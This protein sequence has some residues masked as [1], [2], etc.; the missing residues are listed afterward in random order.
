MNEEYLTIGELSAKIKYSKQSIYN[1]I[2]N[3]VLILGTHY[4]KPTPKKLLF[5]WDAIRL[6]IGDRPGSGQVSSDLH[7][8]KP[9][10]KSMITI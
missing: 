8:T 7:P 3:G 9:H 2:H 6:W 10:P 4:F 1:L 5:S